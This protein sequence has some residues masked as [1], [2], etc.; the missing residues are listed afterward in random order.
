[1]KRSTKRLAALASVALAAL[2]AVVSAA[3]AV[4]TYSTNLDSFNLGSVDAQEGWHSKPVPPAL[5]SGYDQEIV[6]LAAYGG[7]NPAG[8]GT[9]SLRLSNALAENTGEF[10]N[11]TYSPSVQNPAGETEDNTV[12]DGYFEFT[13]TDLAE[14]PGLSIRVSP[15]NGS[16]GR[17]SY[18]R[19]NDTPEGIVATF[20]D[21]KPDGTFRLVDVGTYSRDEVHTVRFLIQTVPGP[22]NDIVQ[23]FIDG[24][25]IGKELGLCFTTW[26]SYYRADPPIGEGHEPG[27][28][29]SLEFR[30]EGTGCET[31]DEFTNMCADRE[32]LLG[33]G[34]LF[35]NVST[36]TRTDNGPSTT[37]GLVQVGKITPTGTTCQQYRD[38]GALT[39]DK[40]AYTT[41]GSAINSVSPGVFFYYTKITDGAAGATVTITETNDSAYTAIPVQQG[42]AFLY[43]ASSCTKLKWTVNAT[44]SADGKTATVTGNL[45]SGAN[46]PASG[47]FIIG[48]K[49]DAASLQK[50]QAPA[51]PPVTYSFETKLGIDV[52]DTGASVLLDKK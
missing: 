40:V 1:M 15:D 3:G 42:Q 46:F 12:F 2:V 13:S 52:V 43:E 5:P 17:M 48:V 19:L 31:V 11:Q 36:E 30:V 10:A 39:L 38:N 44:I 16:G 8:F 37:C 24:V 23:L 7:E 14:Q 22:D 45:P 28:I 18:L 49:Y 26:E 21:A 6:D 29:D 32:H 25:D 4:G 50:K 34:Y 9:K 35:D 33:G 47:D 20:A 27:V 41:K 51:L